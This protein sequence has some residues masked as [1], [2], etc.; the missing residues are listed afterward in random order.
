[1]KNL[2]FAVLCFFPIVFGLLAAEGCK[3]EPP[4]VPEPTLSLTAVD[5]SCTE[6][7]LKVATTQL[8]AIV[9]LLRDGTRVA[10]LRLLT[11]DSLLI[12]EGLLPNRAYTYQLQR[13]NPPQAGSGD[14]TV[15]ETSASVLVTT[16]DTTS[17]NFTWQI[18]TLGVTS[19][20]LYDVSIVN[21]TLAYAVGEMYLRDSTGQIDPQA[22]NAAKWNGLRWEMK[23]IPFI[24]PCSAVLY[25]PLKAIWAFS[26]TSILVTNGG[27]IVTF[28][29][30]DATMDCRMNSLLT[31][32]INKLFARNP[33]D[34]YAVGNN[35]CI[36]HYNGSTWRRVESGTELPL[37]DVFGSP[38]G[39]VVWVSGYTEGVP[40][41]TALFRITDEQV[42]MVKVKDQFIHWGDSLSGSLKRVWTDR[43]Q[44]VCVL[45]S[46]GLYVAPRT[47]EG[48][49]R[50]YWTTGGLSYHGYARAMRGQAVNDVVI[51]G[52]EG[53]IWHFNGLTMRRYQDNQRA[54]FLLRGVSYTGRY[55]IAVGEQYHPIHSKGLVIVGRR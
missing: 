2:R 15:L 42:K 25:P 37:T 21:D 23:R 32:A 35:G 31:G 11:S 46:W 8:P 24:G 3:K 48:N 54:D 49:A 53:L 40:S 38:D 10:D 7:W 36:A 51:A 50:L 13:L 1:M 22:W 47:T 20:V 9:R 39:S 34:I 17:H 26:P 44:Y 19:S 43:P 12:D 4:V 41:G 28:D 18:D 6:A 14:S 5:A 52:A 27:S 45:S 30:T 29:G 16:M 55:F 33:Q